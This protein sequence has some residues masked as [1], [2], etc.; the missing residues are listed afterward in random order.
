MK[1]ENQIWR[2]EAADFNSYYKES[3]SYQDV[4][5][6]DK[7]KVDYISRDHH[8]ALRLDPHRQIK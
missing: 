4:M 6:S 7:L 1:R 8:K 3:Y 5:V 2:V